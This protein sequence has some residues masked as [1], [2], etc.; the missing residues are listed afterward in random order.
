MAASCSRSRT[1][2]TLTGV[3]WGVTLFPQGPRRRRPV[4]STILRFAPARPDRLVPAR[5]CRRVLRWLPRRR[6]VPGRVRDGTKQDRH[7]KRCADQ[8]RCRP[9]RFQPAHRRPALKSIA[10]PRLGGIGLA[11]GRIVLIGS[12]YHDARDEY[13]TPVGSAFGLDLH[14]QAI[15]TDLRDSGISA[16]NEFLMLAAEIAAVCSSS[17]CYTGFS[18]R[19]RFDCSTS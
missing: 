16:V 15:A 12:A 7:S 18:R 4:L 6:S 3:P 5:A 1:Q 9:L 8:L 11:N 19:P 2:R 14:A 13:V 17:C 10:R